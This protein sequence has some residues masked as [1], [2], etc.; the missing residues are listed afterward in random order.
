MVPKCS[1]EAATTKAAMAN[2]LRRPALFAIV[3]GLAVCGLLDAPPVRAQSAQTADA[4]LPSFEVASVKRSGPREGTSFHILPN[5]FIATNYVVAYLIQWAYGHDLGDFGFLQLR[6]NQLVGG[7]EWVR[8]GEFGYEG[9]DIQAKVDD[10]LAE[11][12]GKDCGNA[13][14]YGRCGYR[15]QMILMLQSLFAD[16]FKLKVRRGTREGPVY[17]LVVAKGGPKFPTSLPPDSE[18]RSQSSAVPPPK[19]PPCPPGW[20]CLQEYT[21]MARLANWFSA[22]PQLGR[23]VIDRTGLQGVCYI[24]LQFAPEESQGGMS[25]GQEAG[26]AGTAPAPPLVPSGPSIF[27]ALQQQL[28]LKLKPTK[29]P[30][31]FLVIEHIERPSEN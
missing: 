22:F 11:K 26:N 24:K 7:P 13:F 9:Y 20:Y 1:S 28:G 17:A 14:F 30:G 6:Y 5:R 23:P 29:G 31:D 2:H 27:T 21:T 10:S 16:R 19:R 12:F 15:Q 25:T 18:V 8:G 3:A 4:P